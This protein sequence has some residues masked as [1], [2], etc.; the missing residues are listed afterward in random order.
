MTVFELTPGL[1]HTYGDVNAFTVLFYQ[2][3]H[4]SADSEFELCPEFHTVHVVKTRSLLV[5]H[6]HIL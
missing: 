4:L 1:K 6:V 5:R 2:A 3:V